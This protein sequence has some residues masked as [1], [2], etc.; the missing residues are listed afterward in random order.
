MV[1]FVK[2]IGKIASGGIKLIGKVPGVSAAVMLVPGA[3]PALAAVNAADHVLEA[4]NGSH[5][6]LRAAGIQTVKATAA[7]A[8]A[9]NVNAANAMT[10]L[11]KRAAALRAARLHRVHPK[12]GVV[13][14]VGK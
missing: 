10:M 7:L 3:A 14:K 2:R 11:G 13:R 8:K 12:T 6:E 4:V 1:G 9:G 5:P